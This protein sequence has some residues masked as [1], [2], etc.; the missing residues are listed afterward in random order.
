MLTFYISLWFLWLVRMFFITVL[1]GIFLSAGV[2]FFIYAKEGFTPLDSD[3]MAALFDIFT[4]WFALLV[5]LALLVA[6][7]INMK[8]FFNRCYGG[9]ALR[10]LS[11]PKSTESHVIEEIG[12]GDLR[13]L[14][15]KY[16]L[17][18]VY[19]TGAFVLVGTLIAYMAHGSASLFAWFDITLLYLFIGLAGLFSLF[20]LANF[21]K[22]VR[23]EKC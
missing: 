18:I 22:N 15:R 23:I 3:V 5:N 1:I 19:H 17:F 12:H 13:V 14:W 6:L 2:T 8:H 4:F 16:L 21:S 11:C 10:L 7:F 9:F 20:V